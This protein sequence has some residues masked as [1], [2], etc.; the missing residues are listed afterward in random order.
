MLGAVLSGLIASLLIVPFGRFLRGKLAPLFSLLPISLFAYFCTFLG[1]ISEDNTYSSHYP[2]VSSMGVN[3]DFHLDGLSLLFCLLI[4]GVGS[5]VFLYAASYLQGHKYLDRFFAYL[6]MFMAAML[7]LVLSDNILLLFVFW[8]LTSI[9]SFFLIGFNNDS[10][11]SRRSAMIAL[12]VTGGGG[13]VLLAGLI[14]MGYVSGSYSI[15]DMVSNNHVLKEHFLYGVMLAAVFIGAMTKSAQFPFH[16]WLPGAMKAP[17]PVSAYLHS[18]TMVK[19]G[20]YLLARLFPVLGDTIYW[21]YPLIII[22]GITMLYAAFHSLFRTDLKGILAYST[23]SALGILVFLLGIGTVQSLIAA[24]VFIMVHALYKASL[25]LTT[26]VIDHE[27]GSRDVTWLSGLRKVMMPLA[28]AGGLAALSNVGLPFTFGFIG[29]D[30]IYESTLGVGGNIALVFT[31]MAFITNVFLFYAGFLAGVKPFSGKLNPELAHVHLP[32]IAMWGP[33]LLLAVLGIVFG[34]FPALA[35]GILLNPAAE[36]VA[37]QEINSH[38]AIWH[39]FNIV[40]VLSVATLAVGLVLYISLKPSHQRIASISRFNNFAPEQVFRSLKHYSKYLSVVYTNTMHNGY[41]RVYLLR[42]IVFTLILLGYKLFI[43]ANIYI[44]FTTLSPVSTYEVVIAAILIGAV[45]L[46]IVT[47]SRLTSVVA[48]SVMGYCICLIFVF[49]SAPDLAMTQ[50]TIDTLTVV[51]FV[52]VLFRLPPFLNFANP[53][54]K[55]RDSIVATIFGI[56]I[57]MIAIQVLNGPKNSE[58]SDFYGDNSYLLAK[59]K[60]V[61]NVILV[62]FRGMDTMFEIVVL[63]IAALGVYSLL[64]LRLKSSEKE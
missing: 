18:A 20:I 35:D 51:L 12:G 55:I 54:V 44:D 37:G 27:T 64:K 58:I 63:S 6:S 2:W 17:T 46:V 33:P 28:V 11:D 4:T 14:L 40:L 48:L 39:G 47:P 52:L 16:F 32:S 62:D 7:G 59:G 36:A 50:F 34:M 26:G 42:I 22:G 25:F 19:A 49:Y 29:K 53:R 38:L 24:T 9:S 60:N 8:E 10:A 5:L 61:V 57:A 1:G 30:L 15:Q 3:L 31:A 56:F 41:L 45:Y 13:F 23:I 21:S 43:G